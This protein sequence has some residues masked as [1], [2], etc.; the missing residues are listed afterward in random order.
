MKNSTGQQLYRSGT[1]TFESADGSDEYVRITSAG[2]V[3]IGAASATTVTGAATPF[4]VSGSD[5]Y[6]G[7]S[8]I[9]TASAGAQFQF[10]AGSSGDNVSDNDGLGYFKFFGYHTNGYD[11]YARIHAEVDGTNGDGDAPGAIVFSTTADG[12]SS[13]TERLR[14]AKDGEISMGTAAIASPLV[15]HGGLDISARGASGLCSLCVGAD[16]ASTNSQT[17]ANSDQKDARI[18]MPHY[19]NA[20]EPIALVTG[21]SASDSNDV[22]LGGGTSYL[23]TATDLRFY[24][25]ET[26]TTVGDADKYRVRIHNK[27]LYEL[28]AGD[29][30]STSRGW[31]QAFAHK[32][33]DTD[34][35]A[36]LFDLHMEGG[37]GS[38]HLIWELR[39]SSAASTGGS[40]V[41]IGECW[42]VFRGSGNDIT[43]V[44]V[45]T[46][47][48]VSTTNGTL[49]DMTWSAA[50]Q[51]TS[52]IR[53]TATS[54]S[55]SSSVSVYLWG[56]SPHFTE[57]SYG[58]SAL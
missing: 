35:A 6:T 11:E 36:A 31:R 40:G 1:H 44:S 7:I 28:R 23:N 8:L 24:T 55:D 19:T 20:E 45:S 38:A 17:R 4:Q 41:R 48:K 42:V 34:N 10:A 14:I 46:Y 58:I 12:A 21:F 2:D 51:D 53:L 18:G 39:D 3:V 49:A 52:T 56:S 57:G 15:S 29:G 26:I 13:V 47:T 33:W 16:H 5:G 9:R 50:V 30:S 22:R 25:E 54:T 27:G 43:H 32:A 37:H